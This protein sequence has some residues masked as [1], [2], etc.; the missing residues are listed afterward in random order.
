MMR[1]RAAAV[2]FLGSV[3]LI[4]QVAAQPTSD[5][6]ENITSV[7]V[8]EKL[9]GFKV[10]REVLAFSMQVAGIRPAD[11][12]DGGKYEDEVTANML[13]IDRLSA[14]PERKRSMCSTIK[15]NLSAFFD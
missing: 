12:Q 14:T 10:N 11:L 2:S 13:R 3:L 15:T 1:V 6:I 4:S 5:M 7:V 8:A 9:C